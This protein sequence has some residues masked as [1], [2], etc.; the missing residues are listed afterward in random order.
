VSTP[1]DDDSFLRPGGALRGR[2]WQELSKEMEGRAAPSI[3]VGSVLSHFR[4]LGELGSGGMG[5]V[6]RAEDVA[7]KRP[8]ALKVL[9]SEVL[10]APEGRER[11]VREAQSASALN[12][13]GIVTIY[14]IG[15]DGGIDF[16]AMELLEGR[17]L[18]EAISEGGL[19]ATVAADYAVQIARGLAA[20]HERGIVHR[21]LKPENVF[22]SRD[23]R[24]KILDF[25]LARPLNAEGAPPGVTA[26]GTILGTAGYMSPEQVRGG[27]ADARSD[28]F[29]LGATLYEM[30][31][32]RPAFGGDSR[33][34]TLSAVLKDEPRPLR[35]AGRESSPALE[36]VVAT[37]LRKDPQQRFQSARDVALALE[38]ISG[39]SVSA[40]GSRPTRSR[41]LVASL[42]AVALTV[43]A[44]GGVWAGLRRGPAMTPIQ[45]IA[46]LPL[47]NLSG[48]EE[49]E[50][51]ADGMTDALIGNLARI[52]ALRVI[53]RT[54]TM[55]YKGSKTPLPQIARELAVDAVVEGS[56]LRAGDRVRINA[57][58]THA[59]TDRS[60]W[61]ES[62]ER[63][64]H[65]VL[66]LQRELAQDITQRIRATLTPDEQARIASA[67]PV[68]PVVYQSY[69]KGR[70]YSRWNEDDVKKA[71]AHFEEALARDPAYA[72]AYAGLSAC[73]GL[74]GSVTVGRPPRETRPLE[75]AAAQ[76]ALEID[77]GLA[78]AHASLAHA[79]LSDWDWAAAERGFRR[80]IDLNPSDAFARMGLSNYLISQARW[81]EALAE[82]RRA[83]EIDPLDTGDQ[84]G[85]V[86]LNGRRYDEAIE[87]YRGV[88][89]RNP[90]AAPALWFR[91]VAY[92]EKSMFD[93]AVAEHETALALSR[94]S[95]ALLGSLG[96]VYARAGR[97]AEALAVLKELTALSRQRYVTPA[98][99]VFL[100]AGL[101]DRD[102]AFEWLEK[103]AQERIA[104]MVFAGVYPPFDP[105]RSDPRFR[106]L[107]ERI[108]LAS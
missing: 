86:L 1:P 77:P 83:R 95:P 104:I 73:Y 56:V 89:A 9:P 13:P 63:D 29:A 75:I 101:G 21:D 94:R 43:L 79:K 31:A 12:H 52:K 61:S 54:S 26:P 8:V 102:R 78:E 72:P 60:L 6:Y 105:L 44:L 106:A 57:R 55:H 82:A 70:Y 93:E 103:G 7:L 107:L 62:Y 33:I 40:E 5:T 15:R 84:V 46:V 87:A 35:E 10:A 14:E 92:A 59:P 48:D 41:R 80:A 85:F 66:A 51:F 97:R 25:G 67:P 30:L 71:I 37:C 74:L 28:I 34:E 100:Y 42:V 27:A 36:R 65:D 69:L 108:G 2:L 45:S 3:E 81:E 96:G 64:L 24:V 38:A 19:P 91:G 50:Y 68:D 88:S 16:I 32:G 39:A 76:R 20:A 22:V 99:F 90:T 4:I 53:S 23:G 11:F 47:Q 17:S 18:R 58:L 98:A 49:Q